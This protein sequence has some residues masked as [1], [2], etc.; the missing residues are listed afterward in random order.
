M[1]SSRWSEGSQSNSA[2][3]AEAVQFIAPPV[4]ANSSLAERALRQ[5]G[6]N[7]S[8]WPAVSVPTRTR[9]LTFDARAWSSKVSCRQDQR[10][11]V[12]C[13]LRVVGRGR[14]GVS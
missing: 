3:E 12:V 9:E 11:G 4:A 2:P 6:A 13:H 14:L 5:C 10:T 7:V 8:L 1:N